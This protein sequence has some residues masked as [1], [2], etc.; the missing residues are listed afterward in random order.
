[1][2]NKSIKGRG[3][4]TE[5]LKRAKR[6]LSHSELWD[7]AVEYGF[8]ARYARGTNS[9]QKKRQ[10]GAELSTWS[11]EEN[12]PF[13]RYE[14]GH[15]GNT[16]I[17]YSIRKTKENKDINEDKCE[18]SLSLSEENLLNLFE[19][20]KFE[21]DECEVEIKPRTQLKSELRYKV[22]QEF[23]GNCMNGMCI[24]CGDHISIQSFECGHIVSYSESKNN[25]ISNLAPIC[26]KCNKNMRTID[27]REYKKTYYLS[28]DV[29]CKKD[30]FKDYITKD[31]VINILKKYSSNH[32]DAKIFK[33]A[34][35]LIEKT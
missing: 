26:S 28:V 6:P 15:N 31:D 23:W 32:V 34:I 3:L 21:D 19:D 12:F 7:L 35:E 30:I 33:K 22:W 20:D 18:I 8:A 29:P 2:T 16:S 27:M 5:T 10:I 1:M 11:Q 13:K 24:V 25:D 4:I 14:K 9:E 17:T